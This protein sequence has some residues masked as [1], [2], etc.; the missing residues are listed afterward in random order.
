MQESPTRV[1]NPADANRAP[2]HDEIAQCARDLWV[3]Q[4][5]PADRDQ[6]IWLD[7]EQRLFSAIQAPHGENSGPASALGLPPGKS[8]PASNPDGTVPQ[9]SLGRWMPLADIGAR[10]LSVIPGN[11]IRGGFI[12]ST[13]YAGSS[14]HPSVLPPWL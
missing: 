8:E 3:Q 13:I 14:L 4:G 9:S 12:R 5:Q 10:P 1:P 2:L 7:A 6:A 11:L